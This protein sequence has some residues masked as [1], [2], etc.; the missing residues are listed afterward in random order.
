M[1]SGIFTAMDR[2]QGERRGFHGAGG[3]GEEEVGPASSWVGSSFKEP[4]N[5]PGQCSE[6]ASGNAI[7]FK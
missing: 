4:V 6:W 5:H 2:T 1:D 7:T 3:G